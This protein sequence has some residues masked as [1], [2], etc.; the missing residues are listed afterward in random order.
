MKHFQVSLL[1]VRLAYPRQRYQTD[2]KV[3][4]SIPPISI[5]FS[6]FSFLRLLCLSS[7]PPPSFF[8]PYLSPLSPSLSHSI[9]FLSCQL[10]CPRLFFLASLLNKLTGFFN[11]YLC[12]I[13]LE[14][15]MQE[16]VSIALHGRKIK[17]K[18]QWYQAFF[19]L[20]NI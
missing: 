5:P 16:S 17:N 14:I 3:Y 9:L 15:T 8:L 19:F 13:C 20:M 1:I 2:I 4:F 11:S 6:S 12:I 7:L 10:S 18:N